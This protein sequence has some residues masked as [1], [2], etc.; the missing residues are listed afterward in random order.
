MKK[1]FSSVITLN[2][3][4]SI[5]NFVEAPQSGRLDM[6]LPTNPITNPFGLYAGDDGQFYVPVYS[7]GNTFMDRQRLRDL[8]WHAIRNVQRN[9][10][11]KDRTTALYWTRKFHQLHTMLLGEYSMGDGLTMRMAE[12]QGLDLLLDVMKEE[13][14]PYK[15]ESK[16]TIW[17]LGTEVD[18][19]DLVLA[20][21]Q[22]GLWFCWE[23]AQDPGLP[24]REDLLIGE[25]V[26]A[27]YPS[28]LLGNAVKKYIPELIFE[29]I[30]EG[31]DDPKDIIPMKDI[32][33]MM[34]S[35]EIPA[36]HKRARA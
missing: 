25:A 23:A 21:R 18:K 3:K 14:V 1:L 17:I 35:R 12:I 29:F 26:A 13:Q 5:L 11:E 34:R 16:D 32:K 4:T 27:L 10:K 6:P 8:L 28:L 31:R 9:Y 24:F 19:D 2:G 15:A 7:F 20:L 22:A 30:N 33:M 36:P